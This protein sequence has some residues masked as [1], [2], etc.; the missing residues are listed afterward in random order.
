[1]NGT[2][3]ISAETSVAPAS[4]GQLRGAVRSRKSRLVGLLASAA[5]LSSFA[6]HAGLVTTAVDFSAAT[7][8]MWGPSGTAAGFDYTQSTSIS[9]PFGL[10]SVSVGYSVAASTGQVTGHVNGNIRASFAD[11]L[12]APGSTSIAL[13]YFGDSSGGRIDTTVGAH[14]Q[15][16]SSIKNVGPDFTLNTGKTF[17]PQLDGLVQSTGTVDPVAT[18][19]LIDV[20]AA[21]AGVSMGVT[22]NNAFRATGIDGTLFY[23]REGGGML[24]MMDFALDTDAGL[25][26]ALDL[27]DAG[28]YDF[29]YADL[30]LANTFKAS[31]DL[32][33]N[34]YAHTVAGC[35]PFLLDECYSSFTVVSPTVYDGSAFALDFAPIARTGTAFSITVAAAP[36]TVPEPSTLSLLAA[37]LLGFGLLRLRRRG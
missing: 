20:I 12:A 37:P 19:P 7:Q 34:A 31:M 2:T 4:E 23:Q 32:D 11:S 28:I 22:Q 13:S 27:A 16:T 5:L 21:D 24:G 1:V 30:D 29:W 35:G 36:P 10:G 15:L 9:L 6:A 8:S 33:L 17:T 26:L 14:A 25:N 18:V 3:Q